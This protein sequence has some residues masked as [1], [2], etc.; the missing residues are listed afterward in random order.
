[1]DRSGGKRM[2]LDIN[3]STAIRISEILDDVADDVTPDALS[4]REKEEIQRIA[5]RMRI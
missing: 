3:D 4:E 1:M 5:D 2:R